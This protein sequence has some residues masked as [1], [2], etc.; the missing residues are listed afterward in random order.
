MCITFDQSDFKRNVI[1][2]IRSYLF[3][4]LKGTL[5][6]FGRNNIK[7]HQQFSFGIQD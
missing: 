1:K 7:I 4:R 5:I 2:V 3:D 6:I